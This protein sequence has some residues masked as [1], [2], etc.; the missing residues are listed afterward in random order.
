MFNKNKISLPVYILGVT[1]FLLSVIPKLRI[2]IGMPLYA[3]DF[4]IL[5]LFIISFGKPKL[6]YIGNAGIIVKVVA[7]YL[8]F[9]AMGELRGGVVYGR[10]L[11]AVYMI[12]RFMMAGALFYIIP[13]FVRSRRELGIVVN[14][15]C[16]G[17]LLSALISVLFSLPFTR[18]FVVNT[19]F[20]I[21]FINPVDMT[22]VLQDNSTVRGSTL[23]GTSTFSSGVMAVLWPLLFMGGT[24]FASNIFWKRLNLL[25]LFIVPIGILATYGRSAW[26]SVI[27]VAG[28][29]L[30]FGGRAGR[31]TILLW[32]L[33]MGLVVTK[34][35][36]ESDLL[37]TDR[38]IRNT[39]I[40][41][42]TPLERENERERFM[43]YI[44]P[45][46][47]VMEHPSFFLLG[48]GVANRKYGG[49]AYGE[50]D[51]ASHAVPGIAYYAY[52]VGGAICQIM[53]MLLSFFL[54][55]KRLYRARRYLPSMARIWESLLAAWFGLLP[56]WL[57][58]HGIVTQPRGT[59]VFFLY[60]GIVMACERMWYESQI[61][62]IDRIR[63]RN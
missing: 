19:F 33:I 40:A 7:V 51:S 36:M 55:F 15:L 24:L 47:H 16:L 21:S 48:T 3:V 42:E 18:R 61:M 35:G 25:A 26:A 2:V 63:K 23:I 45:F 14:G 49:N 29:V 39:E 44:E 5:Y 4:L 59:M 58:G 32:L 17:L 62:R 27:L 20:S 6:K 10:M 43:A 8:L 53:I 11:D 9:I 34:I 1:A 22:G 54:I 28:S 38:V 37:M 50:A 13:R 30:V 57:F 12:F 52:G 31:S 56:W 41:V 60:F 46:R